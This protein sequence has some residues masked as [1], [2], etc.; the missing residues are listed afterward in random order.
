MSLH[1]I[2]AIRI[3]WIAAA[4]SL[5]LAAG[6][7]WHYE[8]NMEEA[9]RDATIWA[10]V[11]ASLHETDTGLIS[12]KSGQTI[13]RYANE[14]ACEMFGY[15]RMGGM[16]LSKILPEWFS[17]DHEKIMLASMDAA[18][19][20]TLQKKSSTMLCTAMRKNGTPV[21]VVVRVVIGKSR[22]IALINLSE[23]MNYLPMSY[24]M[25]NH[26]TK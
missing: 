20:G 21:E 6:G 17:G 9:E 3:N 26:K 1:H 10:E 8:S 16:E 2:K 12:V 11:L 25:G 19:K 5:L 23:D 14:D 18:T 15:D 22:V 24:P 7:I 13:I 4:V